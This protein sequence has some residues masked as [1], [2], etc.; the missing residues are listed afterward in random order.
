MASGFVHRALW[1]LCAG[2]ALTSSRIEAQSLDLPRKLPAMVAESAK[3][4]EPIAS[5]AE[6]TEAAATTTNEDRTAPIWPRVSDR[7]FGPAV[8]LD[9]SSS[10]G[11]AT[12]AIITVQSIEPIPDG[13]ANG[14]PEEVFRLPPPQMNVET[15]DAPPM[16][17]GMHGGGEVIEMDPPDM[18]PGSPNMEFE[19]GMGNDLPCGNCGE[20]Q[21][22]QACEA[23][24]TWQIL[25]T[26][27][28]YHSYL[29]GPKE[30]RFAAVFFTDSKLG[31]QLDYTVGGRVGLVRYG[32]TD[33][34]LPQGWQL[35]L[36]GAAFPR[37]NL[38]ENMDLDAADYRVG[39][40][41]T[42][43]KDRW[44]AKVAV[45]HLSAHVG[46]EFLI[47]HPSFNRR[48]YVRDALVAGVSWYPVNPVRL[49]GEIEYGFHIDGGAE[50]WAFQFGFEFSPRRYNGCSGDPF[51]AMNTH[52]REDVGYGGNFCLQVGWQ[53][54]GVDNQRLLRTGFHYLTGKTNQYE[55]L[56]QHE[57]QLGI[58]FWYDF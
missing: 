41:F 57:D 22:C 1:S 32:T 35:D 58:G 19:M 13:F 5:P 12:P 33:N 51:L 10:G 9:G 2:A 15:I 40:P 24:K 56:R 48:N 6:T 34:I 3:P 50:P 23:C 52:L 43:G 17:S 25:P 16:Q 30:P 47:R 18:F 49:Y 38:D 54:R 42:Y 11:P 29:A 26:G 55:F 14:G 37:V 45:Y 20:C 7:L 28:I 4:V 31:W 8:F 46:D 44:Q 53:W 36:E 21:A 39:L 27:L